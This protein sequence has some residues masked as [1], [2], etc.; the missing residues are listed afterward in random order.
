MQISGLSRAHEVLNADQELATHALQLA[1]A[2]AGF[3][4]K[5]LYDEQRGELRR[6][7]REGQGPT[8]Q[9]DDYAFFIQGTNQADL[10][11]YQSP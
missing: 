1:E 5:Y 8:G 7:Y 2:S 11:R 10:T 3:I 6:S 9:A 4:R